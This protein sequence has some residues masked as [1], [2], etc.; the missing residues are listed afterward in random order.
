MS[1]LKKLNEYWKTLKEESNVPH[2]TSD[3]KEPKS[4]ETVEVDVVAVASTESAPAKTA[5]LY[6]KTPDFVLFKDKNSKEVKAVDREMGSKQ[7]VKD[8]TPSNAKMEV[9]SPVD[10]EMGSKHAI[11]DFKVNKVKMDT[12]EPVP[13]EM[14]VKEAPKEYLKEYK[15]NIGKLLGTIKESVKI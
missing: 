9:T 13:R 5:S 14:G 1:N 6:G 8:F 3:E 4:E 12:E 10:R 15:S 7:A 11:D 2:E